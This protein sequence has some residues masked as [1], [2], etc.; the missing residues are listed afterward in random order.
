MSSLFSP[1]SPPAP[2]PPP[3]VP[4]VDDPEAQRRRETERQALL[5]RRGM[6]AG[7]LTSGLGDT[8]PAPVQRPTLLGQVGT[9]QRG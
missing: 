8:S 3:P 6:R 1:P 2:L 4:S 9:S 7:I 5:R